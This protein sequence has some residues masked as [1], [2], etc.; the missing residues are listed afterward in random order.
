MKKEIKGQLSLMADLFPGEQAAKKQDP[1]IHSKA[2]KQK[3]IQPLAL[4]EKPSV[5]LHKGGSRIVISPNDVMS[6]L[7]LQ[8][9]HA[10]L[11][12][13]PD[14]DK[15]DDELELQILSDISH[16][17]LTLQSRAWMLID[18]ELN[19]HPIARLLESYGLEVNLSTTLGNWLKKEKRRLERENT[20]YLLPEYKDTRPLFDKVEAGMVL[21]C[22]ADF[23][24]EPTYVPP[25]GPTG[26]SGYQGHAGQ[27]KQ[28]AKELIFQKGERY[29]VVDTSRSGQDGIVKIFREPIRP[30]IKLVIS[31]PSVFEW[32]TFHENATPL[33]TYFA[34]DERVIYDPKKC[35]PAKYPELINYYTE[36]LE[37]FGDALFDHSHVDVPQM[38]TKD[39]AADLKPMR[40]GKT[41]ES[42]V[43]T[44]L[45][46]SDK[47][48]WIGPR[49]ARIF[50]K[51]DLDALSKVLPYFG[52][53]VIV[54]SL[55][56]LKKPGKIYLMT[57]SWI[58][59]G[60]RQ[61]GRGVDDAGKKDR[62]ARRG[63]LRFRFTEGKTDVLNEHKCPHCGSTLVWPYVPKLISEDPL[64]GQKNLLMKMPLEFHKA[65]VKG[66]EEAG[67]FGYMC[68]N[69]ACVRRYDNRRMRG[70]AWRSKKIIESKGFE[71]KQT[72]TTKQLNVWS[73]LNLK[74]HRNCDPRAIKG[75]MCRECGLVDSVWVPP[76]YR[77]IK[78]RFPTVIVDEVHT[79]KSEGSDVGKAIRTFRGKH[80]LGMTGTLM[81]NTPS[82]AYWP[83]H[84]IFKGGSASFP[85]QGT[86]GATDFYNEFC[87]YVVYK[88]GGLKDSRKMLPY[89][90]NPIKFWEL[91]APKMVR[92]S[93]E[94]PLVLS[95]LERLGLHIPK[96]RMHRVASKMH[97]LQAALVVSS[98]NQFETEFNTLSQQ[99]AQQHH[100]VNPAMVISQMSKMRIAAT[101]PE[102][103]N[104]VLAKMKPPRAPIYHGPPGGGKMDDIKRIVLERTMAGEKIVILSGFIAMRESLAKEF[105][106]YNPIVFDGSWNDEERREAFDTFRDDPERHLWIAGTMEIREGVDLSAAKSVICTDLL[107]QPGLQAQAW[108]RVMT[109]TKEERFCDVYL[110]VME[111]T[112]D[113]HVYNTFYAKVAAAEQAL[114]RKVINVRASALDIRWFVNRVLDDRSHI[115]DFFR[116]AGEDLEITQ[117]LDFG[118][119]ELLNERVL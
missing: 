98:I 3:I 115:L 66:H 96:P 102:H 11:I 31:G 56:D 25:E 107:W 68:V 23:V 74:V 118:T 24:A 85:Y 44:W 87:E 43:L 20:P 70:A 16:R 27:H 95:S 103:F 62:K 47:C 86:A 92:R 18:A 15:P 69:P 90:K 42:A 78:D 40:Q 59:G 84:W 49:N 28:A 36:K 100:L 58:K 104:K 22:K 72:T 35:V 108:S 55:A 89:L 112:V 34:Y 76:V 52:Q 26:H 114:D 79:I 63:Y 30:N 71:L 81:P 111:N 33:E 9:L 116:E 12:E 14:P 93:Y 17:K 105:A 57:Y 7:L 109:P 19:K 110:L 21:T 91:M 82:D 37:V 1:V 50:T 94:D 64:T 53:Y 61:A 77:R 54:D 51:K 38:A 6:A 13:R 88:R 119:E 32:T 65:P 4:V 67:N 5:T 10:L 39:N 60:P 29:Q 8:E 75:R 80:H 48:A 73:D 41:R 117:N 46:G 101:C 45:W 83:L 2:K 97:P 99:A 106:S 113:D